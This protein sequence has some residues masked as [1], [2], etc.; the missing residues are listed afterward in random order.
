MT[1]DQYPDFELADFFARKTPWPWHS[2]A[3]YVARGSFEIEYPPAT[4]GTALDTIGASQDQKLKATEQIKNSLLD[5]LLYVHFEQRSGTAHVRDELA[6]IFAAASSL[7]SI[8]EGL[9]PAAYQ[10]LAEQVGQVPPREEWFD[11]S[12]AFP[13]QRLPGA[14]SV[15]SQLVEWCQGAFEQSQAPARGQPRKEALFNWG[16]RAA[17]IYTDITGRKPMR[18]V[19]TVAINAHQTQQT[20][21][22]SFRAFAN[23]IL[24]PLKLSLSDEMTKRVVKHF[25]GA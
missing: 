9:S 8:Y 4:Y 11:A 22:G 16:I 13:E 1:D 10:A 12:M 24:A 19:S 17:Q 18:K 21:T 20:E 23:I 25:N 3:Y 5:L 14:I 6:A 2:N 15:V 7:K